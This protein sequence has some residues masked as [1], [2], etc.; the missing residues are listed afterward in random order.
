MT[1][2]AHERMTPTIENQEHVTE[3]L[4]KHLKE[5]RMKES[6]KKGVKFDP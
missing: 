6:K 3:K 4:T 5:F 1:S 2:I